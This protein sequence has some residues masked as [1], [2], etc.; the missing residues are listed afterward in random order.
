MPRLHTPTRLAALAAATL[1]A[2][3]AWAQAPA[4]R[5]AA[6]KPQYGGALSVASAAAEQPM[7][8]DSC[9]P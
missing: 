1:L 3:S 8:T 6:E 2:T 4:A 5:P 9:A 7:I